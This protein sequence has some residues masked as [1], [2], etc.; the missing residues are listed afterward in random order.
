MRMLRQAERLTEKG[1]YGFFDDFF[2][3]VTADLWT[4]VASDSGTV[5]VGDAVGGIVV[6]TPSDGTVADNDETY[7]KTTAELFD[8]NATNSNLYAEARLQFAEA[9]TDD[10]NVAFGFADAVAANA[11]VDN[12]AGLKTSFSGAAIYKVDGENVWRCV[13][14]VSTAQT[15]SQSTTAAGGSAYQTL[16]IEIRAVNGTQAEVTFFCDD[17]P[18]RDSN[19]KAIKHTITWTNVTEMQVWAGVKNG[20]A[21]LETLNIDYAA[22]Y[23][24][25]V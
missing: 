6:L 3:Y 14:S 24:T 8:V 2:Y 23:C 18:L 15:I 7:I 21:N 9:N 19:N 22:A 16:R 1:Q 17:Q 13:S 4:T 12:G 5:A 25:R 20:G 11:I 10:A